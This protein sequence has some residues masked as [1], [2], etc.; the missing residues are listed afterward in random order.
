MKK[1][2]KPEAQI[3]QPNEDAPQLA[4][5]AVITITYAPPLQRVL[6][7]QPQFPLQ[8]NAV[9]VLTILRAA[10][11]Q[12]ISDAAIAQARKQNDAPPTGEPA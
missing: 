9:D 2:S 4:P 12:L 8:M 11:T 5:V 1:H 7:I 10:E 3:Q 6:N